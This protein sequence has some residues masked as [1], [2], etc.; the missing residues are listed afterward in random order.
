MPPHTTR[1]AGGTI[2]AIAVVASVASIVLLVLAA[3]YFRKRR[4]EMKRKQSFIV[5]PRLKTR[6]F[7]FMRPRSRQ[8]QRGDSEKEP[9][10]KTDPRRRSTDPSILEIG[11]ARKDYTD[12]EEDEGNERTMLTPPAPQHSRHGSQN[13]DGS[14][15]INLPELPHPGRGHLRMRSDSPTDTLRFAP[16]VQTDAAMSPTMSYTATSPRSSRPRGPREMRGSTVGREGTKSILLK[17]MYVPNADVPVDVQEEGSQGSG[18]NNV[19][20]PYLP[21]PY[22]SPLR[23]NFDDDTQ[24]EAERKAKR[25]RTRSAVSGISLPASLRQALGWSSHPFA[26]REPSPDPE[27][28]MSER[29]PRQLARHS[30][31]D[32]DSSASQ[33]LSSGS[34]STRQSQTSS[35]SREH[36]TD[37]HN[38]MYTT[39]DAPSIPQHFYPHD[40]DPSSPDND[41]YE[42]PRGDRRVSLGFSMTVAGGPTSSRPSLSPNVSLQAVPLPPLTVPPHPQSQPPLDVPESAHTAHPSARPYSPTHPG[43]PEASTQ[44]ATAPL[45]HP[46]EFLPSPTDSVPLTVSDIHFRH[47]TQS[48]TLTTDSQSHGHGTQGHSTHAQHGHSSHGHSTSRQPLQ[49]ATHPPLPGPDERP[50]IIQKIV[51]TAGAGSGPTTPFGTPTMMSATPASAPSSTSTFAASR[52]GSL[53]AAS[54]STITSTPGRRGSPPSGPR[55][56]ATTQGSSVAGPSSARGGRGTG[57]T[58]SH[59]PMMSFSSLMSRP[60]TT[61]Q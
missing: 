22:V 47:S 35:K 44:P 23:V 13:S 28:Q 19:A 11:G 54:G 9:T 50:Y 57:G 29:Q 37:D 45:T 27:R 1:L 33:S 34:R 49:R 36:T 30:F 53:G 14:F 4:R 51:G 16:V 40:H 42:L 6:R 24:Q 60:K 58:R 8:T 43:L 41:R 25:E 20:V 61:Q 17:E 2:A 52:S 26:Q 5:N 56:A 59:N 15:S 39:A 48:S 3:I 21:Q 38:S 31:L 46:I 55:R 10:P 32:M 7:S 18:G 12:D